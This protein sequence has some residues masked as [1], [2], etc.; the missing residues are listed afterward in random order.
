MTEEDNIVLNRLKKA[1]EANGGKK[2]YNDN[3]E[4]EFVSNKEDYVGIHTGKIIF[5]KIKEK[6]DILR[7]F[8]GIKLDKS[9]LVV[10]ENL[11]LENSPKYAS[12]KQ[13]LGAFL[14]LR[15]FDIDLN[16]DILSIPMFIKRGTFNRN[17]QFEYKENK[18]S[19]SYPYFNI[20]EL[21]DENKQPAINE[22]DIDVPF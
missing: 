2:E 19:K 17:I 18:R 21:L 12:N 8:V 20:L 7:L 5:V 15:K 13:T 3:S 11:S 14:F 4:I 1:Q 6:D 9:G 10:T 22:K 16:K